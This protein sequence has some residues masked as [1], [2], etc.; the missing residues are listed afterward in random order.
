LLVVAKGY[1]GPAAQQ[2]LSAELRT[3]GVN[4]NTITTAEVKALSDSVR[5]HAIR[6]MGVEK[7]NHLADAI[8]QCQ[9]PQSKKIGHKLAADA[10]QK[11]LDQGKLRQAEKA[12]LDLVQKHGEA[13]A[14]IGLAR[15]QIALEDGAAALNSL[16]DGAAKFARAG[17]R[18]TA[19]S[20]L[21][22]AVQLVPEDLSAHR[23][24]A[25]AL[26]NQGDMFGAVEEYERF[27]DV[28]LRAGDSR[29]ALLELA[30]GRETLGDLPALAALVDK[31]TGVHSRVD[32]PQPA[33]R[34][35]SLVH[36]SPAASSTPVPPPP[37]STL[38]VE[39]SREA[40]STLPV[41]AKHEYQ[42]EPTVE[43][44]EEETIDLRLVALGIDPRLS[45]IAADPRLSAL[46]A[47]PQAETPEPEARVEPI[48]A[49]PEI[50]SIAPDPRVVAITAEPRLEPIAADPRLEILDLLNSVPLA[51]HEPA[52]VETPVI[53][54]T[55]LIAKAPVVVDRI[56][57]PKEA[58]QAKQRAEKAERAERAARAKAEKIEAA[59]EQ[60]PAPRTRPDASHTAV[61]LSGARTVT[62]TDH[63]DLEAP[64]DLLARA[65]F[66]T[67][68]K[69]AR[70]R[71][72]VDQQLSALPAMGSGL[73]G[74]AVAA[75]RAALLTGARDSRAT[76]AVLDAARRLLALGK[77]Q[78]ASDVLL[79]YIAHGFTDREAQRLLIEVNCALDRRDVA[80]EKCDLL[81]R[82]YRLDG[83]GDVAEDVERL[84]KIL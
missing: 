51:I 12:Y 34:K 9:G 8:A 70:P 82:A 29:R 59:L 30:Y 81:S 33:A 57:T 43:I 42:P 31:V 10:A 67:A 38:R 4:A 47:P 75:S 28:A 55:P 16:R 2:F 15:T 35:A 58:K 26:A 64:V 61:I 45:A 27:V 60:K 65:G 53:A 3:L 76:D 69:V 1:L 22:E 62:H 25:A 7:A 32:A 84:A 68:K 18:A 71:I 44:A 56:E 46:T 17:D 40:P 6:L 74:A 52:I 37:T 14:Y 78:S 83:R 5:G 23:R 63:A 77:L 39:S 66:T 80:K 48:I 21:A 13:E 72:T 36:H 49:E 54:E 20:L 11:L 73:D 19:I 50:E 24:L 41:A 79:D